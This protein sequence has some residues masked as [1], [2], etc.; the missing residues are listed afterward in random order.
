MS[1]GSCGMLATGSD[2][3]H[4][5]G[6]FENVQRANLGTQ[7]GRPPYSRNHNSSRHKA[8]GG[9]G[10]RVASWLCGDACTLAS[11]TTA[12]G[13]RRGEGGRPR[14]Q[15]CPAYPHWQAVNLLTILPR[16]HLPSAPRHGLLGLKFMQR[17]G[18]CRRS[19][20]GSMRA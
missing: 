14:M 10:R 2:E 7:T 5:N 16:L 19:N 18:S 6:P 12:V 9:A 1:S 17:S 4:A 3:Q 13:T 8:L 20:M 15:A 11:R